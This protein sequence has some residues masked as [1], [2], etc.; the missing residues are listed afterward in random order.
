MTCN[1]Y[2]GYV[3]VDNYFRQFLGDLRDRSLITGSVCVWG[4]GGGATK[5]EHISFIPT[6]RG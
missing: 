3:S 4:G 1:G 2:G 5:E 6:K